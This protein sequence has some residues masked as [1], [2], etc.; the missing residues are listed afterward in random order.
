MQEMLRLHQ[1]ISIVIAR[2]TM[3]MS[4]SIMKSPV[5]IH[6]PVLSLPVICHGWECFAI[7]RLWKS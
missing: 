7:P 3:N 4:I 1:S 2:N 6:L 5:M